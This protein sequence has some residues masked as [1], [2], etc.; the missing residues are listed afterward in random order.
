MAEVDLQDKL[1]NPEIQNGKEDG[2]TI[3]APEAKIARTERQKS[4]VQ[5]MAASVFGNEDLAGMLEHAGKCSA[6]EFREMLEGNPGK[7]IPPLSEVIMKEKLWKMAVTEEEKKHPGIGERLRGKI[8]AERSQT[9]PADRRILLAEA[10]WE[11]EYE[12]MAAIMPKNLLPDLERY[13]GR[14]DRTRAAEKHKVTMKDQ[15]I[16]DCDKVTDRMKQGVT[17]RIQLEYKMLANEH[18]SKET[19]KLWA[20][21]I[22]KVKT[23]D[24]AIEEFKKMTGELK[25]REGYIEKEAK[26][27]ERREKLMKENP[28]AYDYFLRLYNSE[29]QEKLFATRDKV[30]DDA[31]AYTDDAFKELEGL[32]KD[33]KLLDK[34]KYKTMGEIAA[35]I[36][37][38]N[39]NS[40]TAGI[41]TEEGALADE[42]DPAELKKTLEKKET[43]M[44]AT[45]RELQRLTI[46]ETALE[47]A[48]RGAELS[49]HQDESVLEAKRQREVRRIKERRLQDQVTHALGETAEEKGT[50][51]KITDQ[52]KREETTVLS[53]DV[54]RSMYG[55]TDESI[56]DLGMILRDTQSEADREGLNSLT[57]ANETGAMATA[58]DMKDAAKETELQ[59]E[60]RREQ[61]LE[62]EV[63]DGSIDAKVLDLSAARATKQDREKRRQTVFANLD[64][65]KRAA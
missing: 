21:H 40:K 19:V 63:A 60:A 33:G 48:G 16:P 13:Y 22:D 46:Q 10:A 45:D 54:N 64:K 41:K 43:E 11:T 29:T 56:A 49:E 31:V 23:P 47:S 6:A 17:K 12:T 27:N 36:K 2:K 20:D 7:G 18:F 4:Y 57:V 14:Y 5:I 30:M 8:V 35:Q 61:L 55:K 50:D 52:D 1:E 51:A 44:F 9:Q 25:G 53:T 62:K 28:A 65:L 59:I 42:V 38:L 32:T 39:G 15:P 3:E 37:L 58:K 34:T 24:E 26:F